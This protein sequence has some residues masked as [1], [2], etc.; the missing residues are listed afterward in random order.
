MA[1][2]ISSEVPLVA[3]SITLLSVSDYE[4]CGDRQRGKKKSIMPKTFLAGMYAVVQSSDNH[5]VSLL[6]VFWA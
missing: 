1:C 6:P 4:S 5:H 2:F 3:G